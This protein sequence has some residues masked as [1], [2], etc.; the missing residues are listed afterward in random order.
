VTKREMTARLLT[1]RA[2]RDDLKEALF[3]ACAVLIQLAASYPHEPGGACLHCAFIARALE[4]GRPLNR[5]GEE[6]AAATAALRRDNP[7][8]YAE[9]RRGVLAGA[10]PTVMNN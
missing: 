1:L 2:E 7:A 8:R 9:M 6:I 4:V 3:E 10:A 5:Y